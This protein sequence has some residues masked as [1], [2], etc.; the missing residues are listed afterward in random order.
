MKFLIRKAIDDGKW[1]WL[2][3]VVAIIWFC[4]MR[5]WLVAEL[6]MSNFQQIVMSLGDEFQ[7]FSPVPLDQLFTY[8]GRIA[9]SYSEPIVTVCLT[10]WAVARGSDVVSGELGRGT[11]EIILS[12]PVTR[13]QLILSQVVV[14]T[15]GSAVLCT[16]V[17][18][19]IWLGVQ[20]NETTELVRP[21]LFTIQGI[22]IP[23]YLAE[24]VEVTT[25]MREHLKVTDLIPGSVNLFSLSFFIAGFATWMSSWDRF[26][27]RTIGIVIGFLVV[28]ST[29]LYFALALEAW[30]WLGWLTV[31]SA[32]SPERYIAAFAEDPSSWTNLWHYNPAGEWDGP[33]PLGGNL[34]LLL[35]GV[36]CYWMAMRTLQR[37]DLPPPL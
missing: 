29:L 22:D 15:L 31:F 27:W 3:C 20:T 9:R 10:A 12:Q 30:G 37:R 25:P 19:G 28:Q 6:R 11:L 13:R 16:L 1:L 35:L 33:G 32:Y 5:V 14:T 34:L 7:K 36:V 2:A 23:N 8:L 26:R 18:V 17:W 24:P 21:P 4:W